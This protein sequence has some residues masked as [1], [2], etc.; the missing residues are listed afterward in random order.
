M[1]RGVCSPKQTGIP[2]ETCREALK[3][4][5]TNHSLVKFYVHYGS[6]SC[7]AHGMKV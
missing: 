4:K 7:F 3:A 1:L 2:Q 6:V 5:K